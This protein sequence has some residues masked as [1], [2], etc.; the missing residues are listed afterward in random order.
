VGND[1]AAPTDWETV[2]R[3]AA[4]RRHYNA[5]RGFRRLERPLTVARLLRE[6]AGA[7]RGLQARIA[8][9]L[10]VSPGTICRDVR[11]VHN[12][13]RRAHLCPVCGT[14][15]LPAWAELGAAGD[16]FDGADGQGGGGG[17]ANKLH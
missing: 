2:C 7:G 3:R 6:Y 8:R 13:W 9:E 5:V 10:G 15:A 14:L 12:E 4:G 11:F 16:L 1:W 17:D